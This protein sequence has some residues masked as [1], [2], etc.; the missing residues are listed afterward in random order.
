MSPGKMIAYSAIG[1]IALLV[2][3]VFA[4]GGCKAYSRYQKRQDANNDVAVTHIKIQQAQQQAQINRAQIAATV[5]EAQKRYEESV[6]IR[7]AQ[8][9]IQKT[10]TPLYVQHE[11]VQAQLAMAHSQ[12][13]TLIWAP[14]G[15]NG[16]PL[17]FPQNP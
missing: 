3:G 13:H 12:N 10:L 17:V 1:L 4:S 2:I 5:A 7:R 8:D 16:T 15:T 14:S 11:A 6:G 9:E